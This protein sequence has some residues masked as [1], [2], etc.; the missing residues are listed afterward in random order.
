M[1]KVLKIIW[2]KIKSLFRK[3]N[4]KTL[5]SSEQT[6]WVNHIYD[7]TKCWPNT[8]GMYA[9]VHGFDEGPGSVYWVGVDMRAFFI[10]CA[11]YVIKCKNKSTYDEYV[12]MRAEEVLTV[13]RHDPRLVCHDGDDVNIDFMF[14]WGDEDK[15][16]DVHL[17]GDFYA[18]EK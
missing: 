15:H 17:D 18:E 8:G 9:N 3:K 7:Q 1:I 6:H 14:R 2:S 5:N 10:R 4:S 12:N 13:M 11:D 16:F